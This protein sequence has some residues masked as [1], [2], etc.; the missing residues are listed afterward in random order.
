M[1]QNAV[2]RCSNRKKVWIQAVPN[3]LHCK[4]TRSSKRSQLYKL[5]IFK[6]KTCMVRKY[7]AGYLLLCRQ[8]CSHYRKMVRG[9]KVSLT[10]QIN[11]IAKHFKNNISP[12]HKF[13]KLGKELSILQAYSDAL[14]AT[15][16]DL[17]S[18]LGYFAFLNE[19]SNK[20]EPLF[21]TPYKAK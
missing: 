9:N 16:E 7:Q 12:S 19:G 3:K 11:K 1:E 10:K 5:H 2:F 18:Q 4:A 20:C 6:R 17:S 21:W 14:F 8:N 13:S 15:N